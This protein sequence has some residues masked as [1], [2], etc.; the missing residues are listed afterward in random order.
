M[1][2]LTRL[3]FVKSSMA[4][5]AGMTALGGVVASEAEADQGPVGSEPVVAY[6]KD[7]RSGE[8]AV[9]SG[10]RE[11]TVHDAKLA[12]RISRAAG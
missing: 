7:P 9:M 6:V 4:A 5:A 3:G 11:V 10:E 8:I 12:A 1:S 2:E